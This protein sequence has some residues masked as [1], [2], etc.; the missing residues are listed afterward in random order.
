MGRRSILASL[1]IAALC[2]SGCGESHYGEVPEELKDKPYRE[3]TDEHGQVVRE[4]KN[5]DGSSTFFDVL[6]GVIIG[7][8]LSDTIFGNNRTT[9]NYIYPG[10]KDYEN[11]YDKRRY[12]PGYI[13]II[14]SNGTTS[15]EKSNTPTGGT[16]SSSITSR[17]SSFKGLGSLGG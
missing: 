6:G 3:V 1:C 7:N 10:S 11:A 4:Y 5:A 12:T 13:P 17:G 15:Y 2:I 8:M 14:H 9:T 16:K